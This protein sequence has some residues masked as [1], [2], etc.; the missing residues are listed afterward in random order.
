MLYKNEIVKGISKSEELSM[1]IAVGPRKG[2]NR[3]V[4]RI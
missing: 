4:A 2:R 1:V 3:P